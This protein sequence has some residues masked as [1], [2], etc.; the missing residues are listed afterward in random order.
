MEPDP[1]SITAPPRC[2]IHSPKE[3]ERANDGLVKAQACTLVTR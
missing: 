1:D 2:V 3:V